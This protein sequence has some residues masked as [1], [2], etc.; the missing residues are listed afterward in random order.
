VVKRAR[1]ASR[2]AALVMGAVLSTKSTTTRKRAQ[3][4]QRASSPGTSTGAARRVKARKGSSKGVLPTESQQKA[5]GVSHGVKAASMLLRMKLTASVRALCG[6][7]WLFRDTDDLPMFC[8]P[9]SCMTRCQRLVR[10]AVCLRRAWRFVV[11]ESMS[12]RCA[13]LCCAVRTSP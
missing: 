5:A 9:R 7:P 4:R 3:K 12:R 11:G 2:R 6:C 13:V 10:S 8:L 1:P